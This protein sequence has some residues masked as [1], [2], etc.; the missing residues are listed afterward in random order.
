MLDGNAECRLVEEVVVQQRHQ[1]KHSCVRV[2]GAKAIH[3]K[4]A[5]YVAAVDKAKER[6]PPKHH[7]GKSNPGNDDPNPEVNHDRLAF[8]KE[9]PFLSLR[10]YL[11]YTTHS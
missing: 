11:L 10:Y 7:S 5:Q 4:W 9:I 2:P 3:L 8:S 6:K 1:Q